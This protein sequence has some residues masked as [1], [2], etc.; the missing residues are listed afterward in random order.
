MRLRL[1]IIFM[2]L[3]AC[4][5]DGGAPGGVVDLGTTSGT[6]SSS[7]DPP[8]TTDAHPTGTTGTPTSTTT[9][10]TSAGDETTAPASTSSETSEPSP[11]CGDG[12]VD[13]TEQCDLGPDNSDHGACTVTCKAA[14]CGDGLVWEGTETCD[15]AGNNN[16]TLYGACTTQCQWGARCQDGIIQ[17]P[18][19]CDL[20][21][22]NNTGESPPN[23]VPCDGC[24]F[25]ARIAFLSS[26]AY[27]GGEL[28]G[29]EGAHLR[30]QALAQQS[31]L[32]NSAS[33]MAWLSDAQH[34]PLQDFKNGPDTA[35]L[36]YVRPDG[37]RIA[38]DWNDLLL[39]GPGDGITVTETGELQLIKGVWTGTAPSGGVFDPA[40]TCKA[41]S[42]SKAIDQ[43][44]I[45]TSGVDEQQV[46][47]WM[48]WVSFKQWSSFKSIACQNTYQIYCFEQ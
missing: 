6:S 7:G 23:G 28:G 34:S 15:H 21:D 11:T 16:D 26:V 45:G 3:L 46:D 39:N 4:Q 48:Q 31:G 8:P 5:H 43:S 25:Q 1:L 19:E 24:R 32:D 12:H 29:V 42:S 27:K 30:C 14:T 36:P 9:G 18:E 38:D 33:F 2:F 44:R 13:P 22:A 35:G 41:W 40:A 37:I 10:S 20:G 17:G 47:A